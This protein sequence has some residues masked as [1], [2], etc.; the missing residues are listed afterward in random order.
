MSRNTGYFNSFNTLIWKKGIRPASWQELCFLSL[1]TGCIVGELFATHVNKCFWWKG[2][3]VRWLKCAGE[4]LGQTYIHVFQN[5]RFLAACIGLMSIA[6]LQALGYISHMKILLN[7]G[8]MFWQ[9]MHESSLGTTTRKNKVSNLL[10]GAL[11]FCVETSRTD[12]GREKSLQPSQLISW[13]RST[14]FLLIF[15]VC[16]NLLILY[17]IC[18]EEQVLWPKPFEN[19]HTRSSEVTSTANSLWVDYYFW[20]KICHKIKYWNH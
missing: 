20:R 1:L 14:S 17:Q 11:R 12:T 8:N 9:S 16:F 19:H 4:K 2:S 18:L 13:S 7:W 3:L 5:W 10:C 15:F 6:I